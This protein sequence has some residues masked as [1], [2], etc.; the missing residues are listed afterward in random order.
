M[1]S[2]SQPSQMTTVPIG[3]TTAPPSFQAG[4][5]GA[6]TTG[7][8]NAFRNSTRGAVEGA[9]RA[10]RAFR[11]KPAQTSVQA[12]G[13]LALVMQLASTWSYW[14][15][16]TVSQGGSDT[17]GGSTMFALQL[18]NT[19]DGGRT[20]NADGEIC[21]SIQLIYV[22]LSRDYFRVAG[23]VAFS[24]VVFSLVTGWLASYLTRHL[25]VGDLG[26][27]G[28]VPAFAAKLAAP[29]AIVGLH[30]TTCLWL[31][32]AF[33][34]Y[35]GVLNDHTPA[36]DIGFPA[37]K[38]AFG[39]GFGLVVCAF[40]LE[41][42]AAIVLALNRD[43]K[44]RARPGEAGVPGAGGNAG[45]YAGAYTETAG[46]VT[47]AG[48]GAGGGTKVVFNPVAAATAAS[49]NY[50]GSYGATPAAAPAAGAQGGQAYTGPARS[51]R[52]WSMLEPAAMSVPAA[53]PAAAAA[54]MTQSANY[55]QAQS[56]GAAP[57]LPP[58]SAREPHVTI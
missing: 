43:E 1:D 52:V 12:L 23:G 5:P 33:A 51:G 37:A 32:I 49:S 29:W 9:R 53:A 8:T 15:T 45:V 4:A 3:A 11:A 35:A 13:W 56:D 40:L 28:V 47:T 54:P 57:G 24:F 27:P 36:A 17:Y 38:S 41:A 14:W 2:T 39:V 16:F 55:E 25:R 26:Q 18:C 46:G 6:S 20:Q 44:A 21:Y 42:I 34:C 10:E 50:G 30:A 31:L 48:G 7:V 58:R 19:Q 22:R